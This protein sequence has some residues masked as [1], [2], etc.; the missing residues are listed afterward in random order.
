VHIYCRT[1]C[2]SIAGQHAHLLQDRCSSIA[3]QLSHMERSYL[4]ARAC[5]RDMTVR[6]RI[7]V[8]AASTAKISITDALGFLCFLPLNFCCWLSPASL[9]AAI[10]PVSTSAL[11]ASGPALGLTGAAPA[12]VVEGPVEALECEAKRSC[13]CACGHIRGAHRRCNQCVCMCSLNLNARS[14]SF[15]HSHTPMNNA[16]HPV[17]QLQLLQC[18]QCMLKPLRDSTSLA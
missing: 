7:G 15:R 10:P 14:S 13:C 2:T 9:L 16:L 17:P 18:I 12:A 11:A 6:H 3:G 8:E 1:T 5:A 4:S